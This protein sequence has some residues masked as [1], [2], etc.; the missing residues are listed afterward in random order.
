MITHAGT[1]LQQDLVVKEDRL[2]K[3][4]DKAAA[5]LEYICNSVNEKLP[6]MNDNRTRPQRGGSFSS[7]MGNL[8]LRPL[9][10][11][12]RSRLVFTMKKPAGLRTK[13]TSTILS[14]DGKEEVIAISWKLEGQKITYKKLLEGVGTD[15]NFLTN[16]CQSLKEF[17]D[18]QKQN[19]AKQ[20][21][22]SARRNI[23]NLIQ[24]VAIVNQSLMSCEGL[25]KKM[26]DVEIDKDDEPVLRV[27]FPGVVHSKQDLPWAKYTASSSS[28]TQAYPTEK[29]QLVLKSE[30]YRIEEEPI[31]KAS[32]ARLKLGEARISVMPLKEISE[33]DQ[34][35]ELTKGDT[36]LRLGGL[37]AV[38]VSPHDGGDMVVSFMQLT[39]LDRVK[40]RR[41][42]GGN[43]EGP[44]PLYESVL[45]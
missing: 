32:V 21:S 14:N 23:E 42:G 6:F 18:R 34:A 4:L 5:E 7:K 10:T 15:L 3:D 39:A 26:M 19:L 43:R 2:F 30:R 12:P 33:A 8:T 22:E 17:A 24:N 40:G 20:G 13:S 9:R 38:V 1:K 35:E 27:H 16:T 41:R 44:A 31:W 29:W 45:V 25:R 11:R 37:V 36:V 28:Y